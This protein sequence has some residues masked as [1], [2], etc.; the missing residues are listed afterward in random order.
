MSL[1]ST[2]NRNDY[3]GNGNSNTYNYT[4]K[5]FSEDDLKV[6]VK[7]S[8]G[9]VTTLVLGTDYTVTD[10]NDSAG[11]TIVLV[12]A[13]QAWLDVNGNLDT[14]F[15]ITIRRIVV[16]DQDT[17]IRNQGDYFPETIEDEFD[18]LTMIDQQQQDDLDRS[19][20]LSETVDPTTFNTEL[21]A[22]LVGTADASI[23]TNSTGD[24]FV[25]GPTASDISGANAS[26][27]AAAAS[28]AAALVSENNASASQELSEEWAT[29]TVSLV[30]T[31][32]YS[33]KEYAIG[34]QRRGLASG[35]SSKDWAN[36]IGGTVDNAE[37]SAK[38][39]AQDNASS[40]TTINN[41]IT[42]FL[43]S[44][45]IQI[46][47]CDYLL[48]GT[49]DSATVAF[50]VSIAP[51]TTGTIVFFVNGLIQNPTAY[52]FSGSTVTFTSAPVLGAPVEA[53]LLASTDAARFTFEAAAGTV[54][55][56]NAAFTYS[57]TAK[58]IDGI[59]V[60]VDGI[61]RHKYDYTV[62]T[63]TKTITLSTAPAIGQD[64]TVMY[65]SDATHASKIV[66]DVL[67]T[68]DGSTTIF[69]GI[70]VAPFDAESSMVFVDGIFATPSQYT[71]STNR[72]F[73]TFSTAPSLGQV[74]EFISYY[75]ISLGSFKTEYHVVTAAENTSRTLRLA[76]SPDVV[77]ETLVNVL[78]ADMLIY[79]TDFTISGDTLTL[80]ASTRG[81]AVTTGST[82]RIYY[83]I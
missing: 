52:S 20:K 22:D 29:N 15:S 62:N 76:A 46:H 24:G 34:I 60:F 18:K 47:L 48:L 32:D 74:V 58:S 9:A 38:K 30:E 64:V 27:I 80:A 26:A 61:F 78:A 79:T 31:L 40:V 6:L 49:G 72:K 35:G 83:R 17:D 4:F 51:N 70:T 7:D 13:S 65:P 14:G 42:A 16:L 11:G 43:A 19:V 68:G 44:T 71:V 77:Q 33:S 1:A 39:Y 73:I 75:V 55:G 23:I 25:M 12:D 50:N 69:R 45:S 8:V 54:N 5:I 28:A 63:T 37:Y 56:I 21:P 81:N 57:G 41:L 10:V 82:L 2:I 67:G 53:F 59:L 36:Y 3:I 66:Q